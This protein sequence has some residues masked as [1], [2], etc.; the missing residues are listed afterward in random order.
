MNRTDS[1]RVYCAF[2]LMISGQPLLGTRPGDR[3][4]GAWGNPQHAKYII[5]YAAYAEHVNNL[6]MPVTI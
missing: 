4:P 2:P 5:Q 6:N 3:R 1:E